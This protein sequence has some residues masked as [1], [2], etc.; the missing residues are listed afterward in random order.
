MDGIIHVMATAVKMVPTAAKKVSQSAEPNL[1]HF[2][3]DQSNVAASSPTIGSVGGRV[4]G[5][6]LAI[7]VR[8]FGMEGDSGGG[9][10]KSVV[11]CLCCL[12]WGW[13]KI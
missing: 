1:P 10:E 5:W 11:V 3:L 9:V 4:E 8:G 6:D 12:V 7:M 13:R 2:S